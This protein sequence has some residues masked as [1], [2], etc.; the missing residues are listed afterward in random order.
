[1]KYLYTYF[2][3]S[4]HIN[5]MIISHMNIQFSRNHTYSTL[6]CFR[7]IH[8]HYSHFYPPPVTHP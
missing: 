7:I 1:M 5:K 6:L 8:E 4:Y 3:F 2:T